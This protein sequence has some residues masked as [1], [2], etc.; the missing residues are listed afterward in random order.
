MARNRY[1]YYF[2]LDGKLKTT[3]KRRFRTTC[4]V[5]RKKVKLV[6]GMCIHHY[7]KKYEEAKKKRLT[8]WFRTYNK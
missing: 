5:C 4:K 1:C 3:K 8:G 7:G 6:K 2:D